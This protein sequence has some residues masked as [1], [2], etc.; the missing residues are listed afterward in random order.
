MRNPLPKVLHPLA[1]R[2]L[3]EHV[4]GAARPSWVPPAPSSCWRRTWRR[5]RPWP[6][7]RRWRPRS[8]SRS[9]SSAPA[10]RSM[11]RCATLPDEGTVLVLYGDTPLLTAETLAPAG[12][13]ARGGGRGGGRARRC[14]RPILR[15]MA[16]CAGRVT[17]SLEIVEDRHADAEL[18]GRGQQFGRDG[19]RRRAPARAARRAAAA[20]GEGRVLPDRHRGAG[21]RAGL[22]LH[23][24]RGAG[25]GRPGRQLAGPAGGRGRGCSRRGCAAGCWRPG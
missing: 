16:V 7:A 5:W 20:A 25:R 9:R 14:G 13:G 15:A 18:S 24:G 6:G 1:G 12:R 2:S 10:M 23:R 4:L 11:L 3:I 17:T 19:V 21:D 8:R 22:A